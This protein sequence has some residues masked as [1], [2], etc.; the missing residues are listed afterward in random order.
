LLNENEEQ[1]RN[2]KSLAAECKLG[3]LRIEEEMPPPQIRA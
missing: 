3:K 2:L 1:N